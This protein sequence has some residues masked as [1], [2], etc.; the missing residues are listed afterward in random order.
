MKSRS[1]QMKMG[2]WHREQNDRIFTESNCIFID[3]NWYIF[4]QISLQA[5]RKN[6]INNTPK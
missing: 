6:P 1:N 3:K 4:I 2:L 5:I